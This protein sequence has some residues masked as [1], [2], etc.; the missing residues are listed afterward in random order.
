MSVL[1]WCCL[2]PSSIGSTASRAGTRFTPWSWEGGWWRQPPTCRTGGRWTPGWNSSWAGDS[3]GCAARLWGCCSWRPPALA[4]LALLA[5][6]VGEDALEA[7]VEEACAA[8]V[9]E[10]EGDVVRFSHPLLT[11]TV[12]SMLGPLARRNLHRRLAEHAPTQEE[13]ARHLALAAH[14]PDETTADL[15]EQAAVGVGRWAPAAAAALAGKA[16][17]LTP[18]DREAAWRRRVLREAEWR[19]EAGD[20]HSALRLFDRLLASTPPGSQRAAVLAR[21]AR[22]LHFARDLDGALSLLGQARMEAGEDLAVAWEAEEGMAWG[23]MLMRRPLDLAA[24]HAAAAVDLAERWGSDAALAEALAIQGLLQVVGGSCDTVTLE[25]AVHLEPAVA[26]LRVLRHPSFAWGYV[27]AALD[28]L[29]EASSVFERLLLRAEE[30]GDD[31]ALP[32]LHNHLTV[33]ELLRGRW[34]QA[35]H[36]IEEAVDIAQGSGQ[37]PSQAAALSRRALVA[38]R[39]GDAEAARRAGEKALRL[40]AGTEVDPSRPGPA[41]AGGG[42]LALWALGSIALWQGQAE[43]A[44]RYLVPLADALLSAGVGAPGELRCVPDTVESL[45]LAGDLAAAERLLGR[46]QERVAPTEVASGCGQIWRLR[47]L[48]LSQRGDEERGLEALAHACQLLDQAGLPFEAAQAHLQLGRLQRLAKRR[49]AARTAL[50]RALE[51]FTTLEAEAARRAAEAELAR[52]GGRRPSGDLLTP[53]ERRVAELVAEGRSNRQVATELFISPKT[54]DVTLS[55][56]YAK[57][58]IHSRTQL[59]RLILKE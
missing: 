51:G 42:E 39:L 5:S 14:R 6:L 44:T 34:P 55:R 1:T 59:T 36:H 16:A 25:R 33:V 18:S 13:R 58:G 49:N 19:F 11:A 24:T 15:I 29:D 20:T 56:I 27:L 10:V 21:K 53:S 23:V 45:L 57:L 37:R 41:L 9:L 22:V 28:R 35:R 46:Y 30:R 31:S 12:Y 4:T 3:P 48:L 2:V 26:H 17:G 47:G 38:A 40:A 32:P 43:E 50:Q 54:V 8:Q 52:L 7:A